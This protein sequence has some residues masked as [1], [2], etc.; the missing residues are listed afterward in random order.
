[1]S[2]ALSGKDRESDMQ[3]IDMR[4]RDGV[5]TTRD[6]AAASVLLR[7]MGRVRDL[8]GLPQSVARLGALEVRFATTRRE[9]RAA[10][11]LRW[12]VF[13]EEGGARA[14]PL[15]RLRR[16]DVC[17]FDRVCDHLIVVDHDARDRAGAQAPQVVG[18]YRLLRGDVAAAHG[19]FYSAQEFDLAPLLARHA[20]ARFLELGRSCV[21]K[22][23]RGK[24]VL[25]LLWRGLW[26]YARHH[27]IDV[28]IG[29]AS[30]PGAES[31]RHAE[32]LAFLRAQAGAP[33]DWL[34]HALPHRRAQ[35]NEAAPLARDAARRALASLPP[36]VKGYLRVGAWFS[37]EAVVDHAFGVTDVLVIMPVANIGARYIEHFGARADLAA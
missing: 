30:L 28:M 17:P 25:E 16:R 34:A 31:A 13:F 3:A 5:A 24:R 29:C 4:M 32:A 26:A 1:M 33:Q 37:A 23:Y 27:R 20:G 9:I 2:V 19:G 21:A 12:Q 6:E 11:R 14:D 18:C 35:L 8:A 7:D 36:L 10:Q 15:A 22:D